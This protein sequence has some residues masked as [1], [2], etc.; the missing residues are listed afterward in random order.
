MEVY[1]DRAASLAEEAVRAA[2]QRLPGF[3]PKRITHLIVTSC[4]GLYAPGLDVDLVGRVGLS[5]HVARTMVGFQGC[6]AGLAGLRLADAICGANQQ[7]TVLLVCVELCTL[8]F[9]GEPSDE[10]LIANSLFGDGACAVLVAADRPAWRLDAGVA[11]DAGDIGDVGTGGSG[12]DG[13]RGRRLT[14]LRSGSWLK[15]DT[16]G[17][18]A[19]R[20]GD[21]GFQ[22]GLS[23]L[24]PRL[25][26][27][28]IAGFL[29]Q[30][31]AIEASEMGD[32]SFW[33]VHPGGPAILDRV[34]RALALDRRL[35]AASRSVL[36]EFGN[37]SSP[38][39]FFILDR[40]WGGMRAS[41]LS[42]PTAGLAGN[43]PTSDE[44][45]GAGSSRLGVALAFGP[46]LTL[47]A[48]LLEA[49]S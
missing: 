32:L 23:A 33:A 7:S 41:L 39:V 10:N 46:G 28:D 31:I 45:N 4:T 43:G 14:I 29:R 34:A 47:E 36:R 26:E 35:L 13:S 17:E 11:G 44:G 25:L 42:E 6:H 12:D 8:H 5:P 9:Q 2:V 24:V 19:W 18:M 16:E 3:D 49:R 38:T 30:A 22:M 20:V 27:R 48:V 37:M 15:P 21:R 1:R 40:I